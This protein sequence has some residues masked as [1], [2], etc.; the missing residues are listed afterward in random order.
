MFGWWRLRAELAE[1][2]RASQRPVLWWRDDDA[3]MVTSE[4]RRLL[5]HATRADVPLCLAVI[6]DGLDPELCAAVAPYRVTVLQHGFAHLNGAG[7]PPSEFSPAE[8]PGA[9]ARRLAEGWSRLA[10]FRRRLPVYV[11]PWNMLTPN[12]VAGLDI[13]GHRAVSAWNGLSKPGRVDAHIDFLRWRSQPRFAG[14]ERILSRLTDLLEW[15]RRRGL[16]REPIGLLTHHLVQDEETWRFLDELLLFPPLQ[17]GV[18]WPEA[19]ALFGLA[20][21]IT[22]PASP[23]RKGVSRAQRSGGA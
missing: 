9:V 11:P 5:V 14:R 2:R 8:D 22:E 3:C 6:P 17:A 13:S 7:S 15:R 23:P 10:D 19:D 21:R 18:D 12:V 4:L 1:W 20:A 16:W